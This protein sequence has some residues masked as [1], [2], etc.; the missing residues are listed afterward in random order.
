MHSAQGLRIRRAKAHV[1]LEV[2]EDRFAHVVEDIRHFGGWWQSDQRLLVANIGMM[3]LI[4]RFGLQNVPLPE[5]GVYS[6]ELAVP[7]SA[8]PV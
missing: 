6:V 8:N 2:L 5:A 4:R 1:T 7:P 3:A